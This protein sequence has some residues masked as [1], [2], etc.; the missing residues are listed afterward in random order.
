[1]NFRCLLFC[2]LASAGIVPAA[3]AQQSITSYLGYTTENFNSTISTGTTTTLPGGWVV[4]P[5]GTT[6]TAGN[7]SSSTDGYYLYGATSSTERAL[8]SLTAGGTDRNIGVYFQ[9]N[10]GQTITQL[11]ISYTGEQWR[12]GSGTDKLIFSYNTAPTGNSLISGTWTAVTALDFA[13]PNTATG[14]LDGNVSPNF[15]RISAVITGLSIANNGTFTLRWRD[16]KASQA[17][18]G[19]GIDDFAIAVPEPATVGAGVFVGAMVTAGWYR[20][21]RT[22][23]AGG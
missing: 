2:A 3:L 12:G 1:M 9:N 15:T 16:T 14:A 21:R 7:G 11:S 4:D 5:A 19:M 13:A 6:V 22:R 8:G 18:D 23:R 20:Q 10:T 17:E